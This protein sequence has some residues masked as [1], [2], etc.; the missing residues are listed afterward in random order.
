MLDLKHLA[1]EKNKEYYLEIFKNRG[2]NLETEMAQI[3]SFYILYEGLLGYLKEQSETR[4]KLNAY[5]K[6]MSKNKKLDKLII[7]EAKE[8]SKWSKKLNL[9]IHDTNK[10]IQKITHNFP[11]VY[12]EDTPI[13]SNENSNI[14]ISTHLDNIKHNPHARPHWEVIEQKKLTLDKE[15]SYISGARQVI[16]NDKAA[17]LV[18]ALER[19]MIDN[20]NAKSYKTIE[21][22]VI[23]NEEALFNTGQLPKFESDL[24]KISEKQYL[25]PTAEVPLT[26]LVANKILKSEELPIRYVAGT[27]CFR[28]EA[29]S[30]GKDT[31]GLIRLHQFRKVELV[32]IGKPEDEEKDFNDILHTAVNVLEQLKLPYRLVRLCSGDLSFASKKTIDIEVWMPGV[33]KYREISSVSLMGDFQARRMKARY[34]DEEKNKKLVNTYNGSGLAIGRT[35]AAIVENY[36]Q[37]D[38]NIKVPEALEKYLP[39]KTL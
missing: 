1:D 31:R 39:F 29:G 7:K 3:K 13:G 12:N 18:K 34:V 6:H 38:G 4:A 36:I 25:I 10:K 17:S 23:V 5:S 2:L 19:F 32:T 9:D 15:S 22:P 30:A 28:K 33:Q 27:N 24:F 37:S 14:V 21:P 26:N 35:F 16:Y 20:A 8:L 11:N